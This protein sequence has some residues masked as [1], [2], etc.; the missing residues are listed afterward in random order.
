[1]DAPAAA[2]LRPDHRAPLDRKIRA[3]RPPR[4]K[5]QTERVRVDILRGLHL[6]Q[7]WI[8]LGAKGHERKCYVGRAI[9]LEDVIEGLV[10][11]RV[12]VTGH[13][14]RRKFVIEDIVPAEPNEEEPAHERPYEGERAVG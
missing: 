8:V 13:Y 6:N 12:R 9:V 3:H 5:R 1:M 4:T 7:G 14:E 10:N 2:V 11:H